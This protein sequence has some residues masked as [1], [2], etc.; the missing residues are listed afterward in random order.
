M[1]LACTKRPTP[2]ALSRTA[3]FKGW[4][5][6]RHVSSI[7]SVGQAEQALALVMAKLRPRVMT[8]TRPRLDYRFQ[9]S[10]WGAPYAPTSTPNLVMQNIAITSMSVPDVI[11][12][13]QCAGPR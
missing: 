2:S 13:V 11:A 5:L 9:A 10:G 3:D 12:I 8:K 1:G 7:T 6:S 4:K